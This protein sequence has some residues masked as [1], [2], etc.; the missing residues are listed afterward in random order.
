[1][2]GRK[3]FPDHH[4]YTKADLDLLIGMAKKAGAERLVTSEKDAV[5]LDPGA[6]DFPARVFLIEPDFFG[7]EDEFFERVLEF[8]DEKGNAA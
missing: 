2:V 5:K 8:C 1:M 7:R 3:A 4:A 6:I